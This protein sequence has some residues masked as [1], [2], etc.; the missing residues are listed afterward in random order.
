MPD[1]GLIVCGAVP[2]LLVAAGIPVYL[3]FTKRAKAGP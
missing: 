3:W 2:I 1:L